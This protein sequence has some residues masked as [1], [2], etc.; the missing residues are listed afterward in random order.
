VDFNATLIGQ[1]IAMLVFVWFCMKYIWPPLL[2]AIEARQTEI[3]DGLAAA[4]K[5]QHRL[6]EAE[7]EVNRIVSEAREQARGIMDQAHTRASEIVDAA[8]S[9]GEAE[10]QKQLDGARSEIEVEINR[11]RDELRSQV[12][13]IAIEGA[14]QILGREINADAHRD[15]LDGLANRL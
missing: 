14:R 3:A 8:R 4:E 12:A 13:T 10:R 11:A 15:L 5:G 7:T 1:S 6:A 9:E 2:N